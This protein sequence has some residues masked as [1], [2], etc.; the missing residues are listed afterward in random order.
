MSFAFQTA[1]NNADRATSIAVEQLRTEATKEAAEGT[2][3][4]GFAKAAG[5]II[6]AIIT[7]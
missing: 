2:K 6:G 3:S 1:N 5:T 7:G 4:A